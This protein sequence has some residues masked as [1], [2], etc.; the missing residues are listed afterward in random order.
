MAHDDTTHVPAPRRPREWRR[1]LRAL[2]GLLADPDDTILAFEIF[3][4]VDRD[5]E[6]RAFRRF[7]RDPVGR[8][9]LAARPSLAAALAD[10]GALAAMPAGSLGREYAAYLDANGFDAL[11]LLALKTELE[12]RVHARG[13]TR[14]VLDDACQWFRD[15]NILTHDLWHVLTGYGTDDLGEAALLPFTLAQSGGIAN[16][17]LVAGVAVRGVAVAGPSFAPYLVEAWR[18]GRRAAWLPVLPYEELLPEPLAAVRRRARI[19]SPA[20]AH[21]GGLRV[22][23]WRA[24]RIATDGLACGRPA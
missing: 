19:A 11:G 24:R 15:R 13:E 7:G 1:A 17:L 6:E 12:A 2:R 16:A 3:D 18:R 23:R 20:D 8:R 5:V 14:P 4:A 9:L 22:G 21:R 10:R